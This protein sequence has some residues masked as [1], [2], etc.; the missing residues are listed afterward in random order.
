MP[1]WQW[2][3]NLRHTVHAT[4]CIWLLLVTDF[5]RANRASDTQPCFKKKV[6][7]HCSVMLLNFPFNQGELGKR[8]FIHVYTICEP[9]KDKLVIGGHIYVTLHVPFSVV[10]SWEIPKAE[11]HE[12]SLTLKCLYKD[13]TYYFSFLMTSYHDSH[14]QLYKIYKAVR[15]TLGSVISV[16]NY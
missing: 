8:I 16:A 1:S 15:R 13:Q 12:K 5:V 7:D 9:P 4:K 6:T 3:I 11:A 14:Q 10:S 2:H